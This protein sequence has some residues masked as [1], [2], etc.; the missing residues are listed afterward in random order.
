MSAV[1][2]THFEL[3]SL[4]S[5]FP[6]PQLWT[7][8]SQLARN[9]VCLLPKKTLAVEMGCVKA[10]PTPVRGGSDQGSILLQNRPIDGG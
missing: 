9:L 3:D 6:F 1:R 2:V 7:D 10:K 4:K 8:G 5:R